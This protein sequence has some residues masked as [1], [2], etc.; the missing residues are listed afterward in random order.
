MTH[1]FFARFARVMIF[2]GLAGAVHGG[3]AVDRNRHYMEMRGPLVQ[4]HF[5]K[6]PLGAIR[7]KGWLLRQCEI[8]RDGLTGHLDEFAMTDGEW[9]GGKGFHLSG[10]PYRYQSNYLEGLIPLAWLLDDDA[11]KAKAKPYIE[12]MLASGRPDGWFLT[13]RSDGDEE[14]AHT[15]AEH[16]CC[17]LKALINYSEATGDP[18]VLPLATKY[19]RYLHTNMARWPEEF[20]WGQRAMEHALVAYWAYNR[21]GDAEILESLR[22]ILKNSFHWKAF[23]QHFPWDDQAIAENRLPHVWD[24]VGKTAHN[25]ALAWSIKMPALAYPLTGDESDKQASLKSIETLLRYHGQVGGRFSGDEHLGGRRPTRGTE[26]CG[27]VEILFSLEKLIETC[28]DVACAD[29]AETVAFNSVPGTMTPDLW[30][31]QYDQQANQVLVSVA[32]REWASNGPDSNI[33]GLM[34]N[35]PCCMANMHHAWPRLVEHLWMATH[36]QGVAAVLYG[37]C[38]LKVKVAGGTEVMIVEE[39]DYP[40]DGAVTLKIE[41]SK[42]TSFPLYLRVPCWAE[43]TVIA[44]PSGTLR[45]KAGSMCM[46]TATWK[47]G[48]T[49]KL[50][51][52]MRL[53]VEDRYHNSA[54]ILRG[55][56][57]YSLRIGKH[58]QMLKSYNYLGASDWAIDPTTPWN[59]ALQLDRDEPDSG[60]KVNRQAIGPYPFADRGDPLFNA[61]T[62]RWT[63]YENDPPV[64]LHVPGRL[65]PAWTLKNNSSDDPPVSPVAS[66]QPIQ[67]LELVPYGCAR[68]RISEFPVLNVQRSRKQTS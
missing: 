42:P 53:R 21:N 68:L 48:D 15:N 51:L 6:L 2:G 24:A 52:P 43:G 63:R 26:L 27:V 46:L 45:P 30:A 40:F 28:G 39:T 9:K 29:L 47:P 11:L 5:I 62:K 10:S 37:P 49:V 8:Q 19:L 1:R 65:L 32:P 23:Y 35:Y 31:H 20:Y 33:Y 61:E 22:T 16:L 66:N 17:A 38:C 14:A 67:M 3:P 56:L 44:A 36:D 57:Y 7:P 4:T 25:V 59:Y 41:P 50:T 12:W 13:P 60:V 64:V 58:Y 34:P 18:R 54:A 55:P